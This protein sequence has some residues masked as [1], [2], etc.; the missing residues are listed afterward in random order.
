MKCVRNR[1][2]SDLGNRL[3]SDLGNRLSSDLGNRASSYMSETAL[4]HMSRESGIASLFFFKKRSGLQL[5]SRSQICPTHCYSTRKPPSFVCRKPPSFVVGSCLS[6]Y[7]G[8][9]LPSWQY[10]GFQLL[11][12]AFLFPLVCFPNRYAKNHPSITKIISRLKKKGQSLSV[13]FHVGG[14]F[15]GLLFC[16]SF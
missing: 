12:A 10:T 3:S 13:A 6:S 16:L 2:S 14:R 5:L 8:S 7:V 1:L 9:H 4:L 15:F 11:H